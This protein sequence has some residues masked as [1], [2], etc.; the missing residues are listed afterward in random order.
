[1]SAMCK[2]L[3]LTVF[4]LMA[5]GCGDDSGEDGTAPDVVAG[6]GGQ[7]SGGTGGRGNAGSPGTGGTTARRLDCT[8]EFGNPALALQGTDEDRPV[9]VSISHDELELFYVMDHKSTAEERY[10]VTRRSSITEPFPAGSPVEELNA[11]CPANEWKTMDV[12]DDGLR[13]YVGCGG[14][15]ALPQIVFTARR[16]SRSAPFQLDDEPVLTKAGQSVSVAS[17]ELM[18]FTSGLPLNSAPLV[19]TRSSP[20]EP[21]GAGLPIPGFET[22]QN[23]TTPDISSDGLHLYVNASGDV[24]AASRARLSD[25]FG[26]MVPVVQHSDPDVIL[27]SPAITIDCR[28]LYYVE[29]SNTSPWRVLVVRR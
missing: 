7:A 28:A 21:F 10:M 14:T 6:S 4:C 19:F 16:S 11:L 8:G 22:A 2:G 12:T 9:S 5:L 27:G 24:A 25:P 18:A 13:A 15:E 3:A 26:A 20:G 1:M 17:N 29:A 23:V